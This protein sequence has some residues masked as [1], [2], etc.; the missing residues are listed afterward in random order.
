MS[1]LGFKKRKE[2]IGVG[3]E[4][5]YQPVEPESMKALLSYFMEMGP[6]SKVKPHESCPEVQGRMM[7]KRY[8]SFLESG[9]E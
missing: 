5:V 3:E 2:N 7:K 1:L 9:L 6:A 4:E 8:I